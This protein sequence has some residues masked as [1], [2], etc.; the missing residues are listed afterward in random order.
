MTAG[1]P[2]VE[3]ASRGPDSALGALGELA[4]FVARPFG[5]VATDLSVDL[6]NPIGPAVIT[7]I[8]ARCLSDVAASQR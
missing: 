2:V 1:G 6:S 3:S 4:P 7:H 5:T 8:L